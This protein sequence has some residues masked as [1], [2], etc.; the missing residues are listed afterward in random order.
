M[1]MKASLVLA[2]LAAVADPALAHG[3]LANYTVGDTWYRGSV[4]LYASYVNP[5]T[6]PALAMTPTTPHQA[7]SDSRGWSKGSGHP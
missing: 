6:N 3:G 1:A 4:S 7:S 2:A 5:V